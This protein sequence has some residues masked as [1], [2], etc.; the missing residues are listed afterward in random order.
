VE[1]SSFVVGLFNRGVSAALSAIPRGVRREGVVKSV[2]SDVLERLSSVGI[3]SVQ[4]AANLQVFGLQWS[5]GNGLDYMTLDEALLDKVL[6]VAEI[7]EGGQVPTLKVANRSKRMVFL[8]A[9]ELL[10]GCKQDRVLNTSLMIPSKSEMAIPVACV[11]VGRWG[12][13]SRKFRSGQTSSHGYLRAILSKE[14]SAQYKSRSAPGSAQRAVWAEVARKM[15][16]MG[17]RSS[18][19][20]LQDMFRD[21]GEKLDQVL[22]SISSPEGCNGVAFAINGKILGIDLFDKPSTLNKLWQKL[23]KSYAMDALEDGNVDRK[24]LEPE[25]VIEW[26]RSAHSARQEWF[27]SPGVGRDVRIE[28]EMVVG[29][30]LVVEQQP[31]HL[32]LFPEVKK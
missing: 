1:S 29:A 14:T 30:A 6:D 5:A 22:R 28:G 20:A 10:V 3:C 19:G 8:M 18:S 16:K 32:E 11:E 25:S 7:N 26:A 21:Y 31:V 4:Q 9:G 24:L 27:D 2:P 15:G 17:S 23:I 13:Q 12:Y